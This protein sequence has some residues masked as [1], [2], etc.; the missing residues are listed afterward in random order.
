MAAAA[1]A[2]EAEAAAAVLKSLECAVVC[3]RECGGEEPRRSSTRS[4][5][6]ANSFQIEAFGLIRSENDKKTFRSLKKR[7][8]QTQKTVQKP[9]E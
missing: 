9:K 7:Q 2:A 8:L 4:K 6:E 5:G 1:A 3:G